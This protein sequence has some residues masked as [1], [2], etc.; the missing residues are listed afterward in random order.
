M[1]RQIKTIVKAIIITILAIVQITLMSYFS[2]VGLWPNLI[3][4]LALVL[5]LTGAE[6][7]AYLTASLGGLIL[8]LASPLF[9]GF[10]TIILLI[11]VT[12]VKMLVNK[13]LSEISMFMAA[14]FLIIVAISVDLMM[15]LITRQFIFINLIFNVF[16]TLIIGLLMFRLINYWFRGK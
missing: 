1:N 11:I 7:E 16:Y 6:P 15:C 4:I 12:L 10:N 13:F 8:D 5:V 9:F 14:L 2:I 3:F